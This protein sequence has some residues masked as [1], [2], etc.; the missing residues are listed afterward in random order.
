MYE[1]R[2]K[3]F[4]GILGFFVL[5]AVLRLVWIQLLP[6]SNLQD[7]IAELRL[8]RDLSGQ[9][10]TIR[11]KILDRKGRV[12]ADDEL[13]FQVHIN[14]KLSCFLDERV[15]RAKLLRAMK[16]ENSG[17]AAAKVQKELDE[18]LENLQQVIEKCANFG[19]DRQEIESRIKKI[20]DEIWNLRTFM[21]WRRSGISPAILGKYNNRVEK[22]PR[23]TAI[24]DFELK[25]PNEDERR[26]L[27]NKVD[28]LAEMNENWPLLELENDDDI[29]TAQLEFLDIDGV[30]ILPEGHRFYYYGPAASQTIGWVGP[31][32]QEQD[33]EVFESDK[34]SSYLPGEVCGREDGVEYV[35]EA[36]LRGR[37]GEVT[38]DIDG[39]LLSRTETQFGKDVLLTLDIELQKRIENHLTDCELNKNCH[40]PTAAVVM[41]VESGDILALVSM[42]TFDLNSVRQK[43]AQFASDTDKPMLNRA[44]NQ[45]YPPG[46]A[47]K[48]LILIAG[49]ES[50]K[51]TSNE[52]IHCPAEP[53]PK[54]WPN[55][56]QFTQFH[57]CHDW[58]WDGQGGNKARNAIK[59]SCNIYFSRLAD[60]IEP[61][62]LQRWLFNFG[63]GHTVLFPPAVITDA[64][65]K[66]NFRQAQGQISNV[67]PDETISSF[68]QVGPLEN[69]E[70][71]FFGIGQGN[72]RVTPLQV[73]NA[74]AAIARNGKYKTARLIIDDSND[75]LYDT[76]SLNL[77]RQTIEAVRDGMDAVVN[78]SGG[79]ANTEFSRVNLGSRGV[80]VYGKT[81]ST[82]SPEH[83]WFAGFAQDGSGRT[84]AISVVVEGGKHGS[85]DAAPL[86]RDIIEFCIDAGYIGR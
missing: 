52:I 84:I 69:R 80:K 2:V 15:R 86:A 44:I 63:Y 50:G 35:C 76:N 31:A 19:V 37:R 82:E 48:P 65:L 64:G 13:Q 60:R 9:L 14:Y 67:R 59:G 8:A 30:Q 11:G 17:T 51:I 47:I 34:L 56:L 79:T 83:A 42:P 21:A 62:I 85:S 66:R 55:C 33:R 43:Y 58:K 1:K 20:N 40:A 24:A 16:K 41:D 70:R 39:K 28:N 3:I 32:T 49:M 75:S 27:I 12:L 7:S 54:G 68:E 25:I 72:L 77:S 78:E 29:F 38:Y 71:K 22:I 61:D 73:A 74:M 4:A 81:G 46:S 26:R 57:S 6:D 5:V 18:K 10:K 23:S 36:F 53:A 45:T